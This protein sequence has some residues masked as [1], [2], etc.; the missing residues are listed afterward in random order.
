MNI[1][2][3]ATLETCDSVVFSPE[4]I[5]TIECYLYNCADDET[6][7]NNS[8]RSNMT[9]SDNY[10]IVIVRKNSVVTSEN[11]QRTCDLN[12]TYV[13]YN[14]CNLFKFLV[15]KENPGNASMA[16]NVTFARHTLTTTIDYL[17]SK[18]NTAIDLVT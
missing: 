16:T 1:K 3:L 13:P 6:Y 10:N 12:S 15:I 11:L 9:Y 5:L 2:F 14:E 8:C 4:S 17:H 18:T 7:R